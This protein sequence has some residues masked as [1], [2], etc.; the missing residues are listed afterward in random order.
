[1]IN[2]TYNSGNKKDVSPHPK[3]TDNPIPPFQVF[4]SIKSSQGRFI[5]TDRHF[6]PLFTELLL[7]FISDAFYSK[8]R[9]PITYRCHAMKLD[10][11]SHYPNLGFILTLPSLVHLEAPGTEIMELKRLGQHMYTR[12]MSLLRKLTL[13]IG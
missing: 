13:K 6:I 1:M 7:V 11:S 8:V 5:H 12:Q 3:A 2:R 10:R 4:T 9:N